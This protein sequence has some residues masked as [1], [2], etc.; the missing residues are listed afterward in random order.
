LIDKWF[1]E[2][3]L[4]SNLVQSG[5]LTH[6]SQ[7]V[8][9]IPIFNAMDSLFTRTLMQWHFNENSRQ[10]P[11]KAVKDPYKIWLSEIILQQTR[12]SQGLAYYERFTKTYP[13]VEDLAKAN[14]GDVFKLWEGLGYYNRCKN[15]LATARK[16]TTDFDGKFPQS[17]ETLL[18]L[19]GI[20][21]YTA[22][23]IASFAFQLPYAVVDGNVYRVL[24]RYF[25]IQI[26]IDSTEGKQHFQKLAD[27]LL[28]KA[29]PSAFN[30][31]IMDFGATICKP[32][33][34]VCIECPLHT[35]CKAFNEV[36]VN[37]LPVKEKR[38]SKKKRN[39]HYFVFEYK[40]RWLIQK[41]IRKDIWQNLYEFYLLESDE[42]IDWNQTVILDFLKSQ[43]G[44]HTAI[45]LHQSEL[46][47]QQLTHQQI[48][49]KFIRVK[50]L[51]M[52]AGLKKFDWF[53]KQNISK[54]PFPKIIN[55]WL[56]TTDLIAN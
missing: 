23:A 16:I 25:G 44:I 31:A 20:G 33:A 47:I 21:P 2:V 46:H 48:K 17:Y 37:Q 53:T 28:F 26:P 24:S 30:Q 4:R 45:I 10:M 8:L 38:L 49:A 51:E 56:S 15:L 22:A 29:D 41:R 43:I 34:P 1:K 11:W 12:V 18:T 50:L 3:W 14:D 19:K 52:P 7:Q 32:I 13:K 42:H 55:D 6:E 5:F 40:Q 39:F 27:R 35:H 36:L 54:L 9:I